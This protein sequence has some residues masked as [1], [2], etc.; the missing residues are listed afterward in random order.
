MSLQNGL[1]LGYR[2]AVTQSLR[3]N[4]ITGYDLLNLTMSDIYEWGISDFKHVH[5]LFS[6][7][8]SLTNLEGQ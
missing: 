5:V 8:K 6:H 2:Q 1:F 7:L 4:N 3:R